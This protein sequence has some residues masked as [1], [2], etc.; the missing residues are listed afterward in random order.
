M[1]LIRPMLAT[2]TAEVPTGAGWVFEEKYDGIRALAYRT[3]NRVRLW[4]RNELELTAGFPQV[5]EAV[6]ALPGGNLVLDGELVMFD[7]KGVSRFQLLQRRGAGGRSSYAVFDLLERDGVPLVRRPLT[8][9]RT[10]LEALVGRGAVLR[11][12]RRVGKNGTR[13]HA[14]AKEKSWEGIIAKD[15][16]SV[17]EPGARSRAWLKVKVRKQSEFV[18]GGFTAPAGSR[19]H[20]GALLVG[21]YDGKA[22]RFAGKVGSGYTG[23][24]LE[25]L[26]ARLAPIRAD[27]SPFADAPRMKDATWV[28]PR[29]VAQIAFAEWTA[30][31]KLRQPVFQGLR[32]DKSPRECRWDERER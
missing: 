4:S 26:A 18:I 15:E 16:T 1:K 9:R 30:D 21:L 20:L 3:N 11:L 25:D 29:L 10:A 8:E 31:R 28:K 17:Y 14:T 2:L 23:E 5:A 32:R 19:A 24:S 7:A 13:A 27:A 22:L 12:S 6:A